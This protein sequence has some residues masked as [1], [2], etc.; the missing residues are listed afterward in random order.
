MTHELSGVDGARGGGEGG[1][2]G[3]EGGHSLSWL[4]T[5]GLGTR[6]GSS[7]RLE[8]NQVSHLELQEQPSR[9]E[10]AEDRKWKSEKEK[11]VGLYPKVIYAPC[12]YRRIGGE[13]KKKNKGDEEGVDKEAQTRRSK[14]AQRGRC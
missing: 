6:H 9:R 8:R 12:R 14:A 5:E 1:V 4:I 3:G 7:I 11:V 2:L 13:H 10:E